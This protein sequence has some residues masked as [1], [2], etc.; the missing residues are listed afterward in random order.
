MNLYNNYVNYSVFDGEITLEKEA[1][2]HILST[3]FNE[4]TTNKDIQLIINGI[5]YNARLMNVPS[6]NSVQISYKKEVKNVFK[7]IFAYSYNYWT[8][9]RHEAK[10]LNQ[11]TRKLPEQHVE[12]ISINETHD[13]LVYEV[14]CNSYFTST[15]PFNE[16]TL[17]SE[18]NILFP[19]GRQTY[20]NH[21]RYERNQAV[22]NLA[23]KVFK[24]THGSLYCEVCGF[25]FSIYGDRGCDFIEAHHDV[26][27]VS[28][29]GDNATSSIHDIKMVCSNC[30][31][32][33]HLKR[34]WLKVEEL[35]ALINS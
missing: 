5:H 33:L 15:N 4:D 2:I 23:K 9:L 24:E 30:H 3:I 17:E 28:Q 34:P 12:T 6:S 1:K 26:I 16:N 7:K 31:R 11:S 25:S 21:V 19:E 20:T 14:K 29:M 10:Q 13:P 8:T 27:P 18:E 22:I 32:I 35:K